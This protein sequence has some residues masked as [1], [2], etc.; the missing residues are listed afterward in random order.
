MVAIAGLGWTVA[1]GSLSV[2]RTESSQSRGL[3]TAFKGCHEAA[4]GAAGGAAGSRE[5]VEGHTVTGVNR[6]C[7]RGRR[8]GE[9]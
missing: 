2:G 9:S 4:S 5:G 7:C 3:T 8:G 6:V 1:R